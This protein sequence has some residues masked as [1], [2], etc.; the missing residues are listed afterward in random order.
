MVMSRFD[1]HHSDIGYFFDLDGFKG[2]YLMSAGDPSNKDKRKPTSQG[3]PDV[4]IRSKREAFGDFFRIDEVV[5]SQRQRDGT[6]SKDK[7]RLIFERGDAVSALIYNCEINRVVLVNEFKV[8]TLEKGRERGWI[9]EAMAG[10]IK[11][12]ERPEDALRREAL[13]ETG[14]RLGNI[15]H[16]ASFFSSPGGSSERIFLYYAVVSNTD[17]V[18]EG[19]GRSQDGEEIRIIE[20]TPEQLFMKLDAHEIEDPKLIIASHHLRDRLRY[21][22]VAAEPLS[23][24]TEFYQW[25]GNPAAGFRLGLKLGDIKSVHGVDVWVNSENTDMIMDRLIGRSV[26][27]SIR[28]AGAE[29]DAENNIIEDTIAD[30]LKNKL[31]GRG[32][33]RIGT[34]LETVP[35]ALAEYGVKRIFHI[36]TAYSRP[37][38]GITADPNAIEECVERVLAHAHK[39]NQGFR[40]L[41]STYKSILIPLIGTGDGGLSREQVAPHLVRSIVRF[42]KHHGDTQLRDVFI[43]CFTEADRAAVELAIQSH[44]T[45]KRTVE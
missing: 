23:P 39:R 6:M 37:G 22:P 26:S 21:K 35:G 27:A 29:K 24:D 10:M 34:I 16:I 18:G 32:H 14:Y 9:T 2:K 1:Y 20:M 30:D 25:T 12:G 31:G 28:F 41:R 19:G 3:G 42:F 4:I 43:L 36:A 13:E 5:F 11:A 40:L 8:P 44:P 45:L 7:R 17:R 38:R 15:E 33:V